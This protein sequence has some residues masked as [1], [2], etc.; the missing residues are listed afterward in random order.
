MGP[1]ENFQAVIEAYQFLKPPFILVAANFVPWVELIFGAFL[2]LGF[3]T[4]TSATSLAILSIIFIGLLLRS[5]LLHLPISECGCF[6]S[7][8]TLAPWQAIILDAGLL[9]LSLILIRWRSRLFSLD[10]KLHR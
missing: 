5:L 4:R 1:I 10:E 9:I 8:I 6:G 7:K 3:L 2:L